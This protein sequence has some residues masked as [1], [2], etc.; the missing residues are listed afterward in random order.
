MIRRPPRSTRTDT[1]FP[2]TPLFRSEGVADSRYR[3]ESLAAAAHRIEGE[4]LVQGLADR[5]VV[6]G[7]GEIDLAA[8]R[9]LDLLHREGGPPALL[10]AVQHHAD[11]QVVEALGAQRVE[12]PACLAAAGPPPQNGSAPCRE[13]RV[14]SV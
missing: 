13:R 2:Y 12:L 11:R 6:I 9:L 10:E 3:L 5:A 8:Q 1:L 14:L 4:A 7:D